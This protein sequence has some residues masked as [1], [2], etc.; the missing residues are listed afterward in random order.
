MVYPGRNDGNNLEENVK[1]KGRELRG[2]ERRKGR[3]ELQR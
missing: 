1:E 2:S 3:T